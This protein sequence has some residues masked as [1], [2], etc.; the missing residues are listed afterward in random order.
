MTWRRHARADVSAPRTQAQTAHA[1]AGAGS[2]QLWHAHAEVAAGSTQCRHVHASVATG[3]TGCPHALAEARDLL[4]DAAG[5]SAKRRQGPA[6]APHKCA[7]AG[8]WRTQRPQGRATVPASCANA[9]DWRASS[10]VGYAVR[11]PVHAHPWV[12]PP[13][14]PRLTHEYPGEVRQ[15]GGF[16]CQCPRTACASAVHLSRWRHKVNGSRRLASASA[17]CARLARGYARSVG[18]GARDGSGCI[19]P[20]SARNE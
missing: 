5:A 18:P 16:A 3:C 10:R 8:H 2:T 14:C 9:R 17:A 13:P 4:S 11:T 19:D 15:S 1:N 12:W 6:N 20:P 7:K